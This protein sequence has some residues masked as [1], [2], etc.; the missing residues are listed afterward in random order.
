MSSPLP[1]VDSQA[2]QQAL[3]AA[4]AAR[5]AGAELWTKIFHFQYPNQ[6]EFIQSLPAMQAWQA[7]VMIVLGLIYMLYGWKIFKVLVIVNA[8]ALGFILGAML[9]NLQ[10]LQWALWGGLGGAVLLA[11]LALPL[12]RFAVALMGG[13]VGSFAGYHIWN[14]VIAIM[15][16]DDLAQFSW[17]GAIIGL[18]VL[19]ALTFLLFKLAVMIFTSIQG[20]FVMVSGMLALLLRIPEFY[21]KAYQPLVTNV[22]LLPILVAG[23]ALLGLLLQIIKNITPVQKAAAPPAQN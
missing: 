13:L 15:H 10:S 18:L 9:G 8:M 20:S 22:H 17:A 16:R 2:Q 5:Q 4:E 7:A 23:P 19:G 14:Y 6:Q 3:Q 11:I 12:M 21:D 1:Q